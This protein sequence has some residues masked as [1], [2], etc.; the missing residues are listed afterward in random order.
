MRMRLAMLPLVIGVLLPLATQAATVTATCKDGTS[1][2]GPTKKGACSGHG[3]VKAWDTAAAPASGSSPTT[4]SNTTPAAATTSAAKPQ[5]ETASRN[6]PN[7]AAA[8]VP[9]GGAGQVWVNT[10]TKVYHCAGSKWYGKTKEGKYMP[11]AEAK[12]AG[13]HG[14]NGKACTA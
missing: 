10:S 5:A 7:S 1:F 14:E 4:A 9:G 3:G 8:R 11:E 12:A 2:S 13:Y 6:M